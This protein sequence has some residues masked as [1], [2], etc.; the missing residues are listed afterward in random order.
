MVAHNRYF[1]NNP[2]KLTCK[3][4]LKSK[5]YYTM[6]TIEI[7]S[8]CL[9]DHKLKSCSCQVSFEGLYIGLLLW[10]PSNLFTCLLFCFVSYNLLHHCWT[11]FSCLCCPESA[12]VADATPLWL[13]PSF[14]VRSVRGANHSIADYNIWAF[15]LLRLLLHLDPPSGNLIGRFPFP[16]VVT[17]LAGL[18]VRWMVMDSS[19]WLRPHIAWSHGCSQRRWKIE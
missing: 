1:Y 18:V 8:M 3:Q 9:L 2:F 7:G 6:E 10:Y 17:R 19:C 11:W 5:N 15:L 14:R 13:L 16:V 4:K 12:P